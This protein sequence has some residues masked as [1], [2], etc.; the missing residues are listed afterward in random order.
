M[1]PTRH[2][3]SVT[4]MSGQFLAYLEPMVTGSEKESDLSYLFELARNVKRSL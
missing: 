1:T 4:L 2:T 3:L